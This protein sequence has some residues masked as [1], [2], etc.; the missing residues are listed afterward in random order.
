MKIVNTRFFST[1]ELMARL[2][3]VTMLKDRSVL[4]YANADITVTD[5]HTDQLA[6]AQL[7]T[8]RGE[9]EKVRALRWALLEHCGVDI[10]RLSDTKIRDGTIVP[11]GSDRIEPVGF[12]EFALEGKPE[13][14]IT[15]LPPIVESSVEADRSQVNIINDGMHRCFVAR[16]SLVVPAVVKIS[17]IPIGLPYYAFPLPN[18]WRDVTMVDRIDKGFLKKYHRF[19][20]GIYQKYYRDFN[21]AFVNVG[22]P[23]GSD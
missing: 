21:S 7:Y 22:G 6:P 8:L 11:T 1:R 15:I 4:P 17:K 16:V 18:G 20:D 19:P 9:F 13:E 2:R 14:T 3:K 5:I 12:V 10:L 23:R